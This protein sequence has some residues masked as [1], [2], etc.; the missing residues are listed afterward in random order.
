MTNILLNPQTLT[1]LTRVQNALPHAL[2]ITGK[3]GAG[4]DEAVEFIVRDTV[5]TPIRIIPN[6]K[7]TISVEMIRKIYSQ[8]N[9]KNTTKQIFI[10]E[11]AEKM[12]PSAQN[13]LLKRLE[14]PLDTVYFILLT[15]STQ[16]LLPTV[17][18]RAQMVS[19]LPLLDEQYKEFLD[20]LSIEKVKKKQIEHIAKGLPRETNKLS[21]D[22]E[23]FTKRSNEMSTAKTFL[24]SDSYN[25]L[26]TIHK[27][28]K[29]KATT[30]QLLL[31][32]AHIIE[33]MLRLKPNNQLVTQLNN[34][35]KVYE[36]INEDRNIRI[37]LMRL[38]Q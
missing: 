32:C 18:S 6:E 11:Q 19:V 15:Y 17:K 4:L 25:K 29:D 35:V 21:Q 5:H 23:Y 10:V 31:D 22:D 38:I 8:S 24:Q 33:T 16:L 1:Q 2:I 7:N 13:A 27:I 9:T 30:L 36:N 26:V 14:E 20:T 28:S 37:Q 3:E 34:I 12:S